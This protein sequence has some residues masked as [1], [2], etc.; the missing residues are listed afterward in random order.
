MPRFSE[1]VQIFQAEEQSRIERASWPFQP[2]ILGDE[3][4][5]RVVRPERP[6][7]NRLLVNV[8]QGQARTP[9]EDDSVGLA[10]L[11]GSR[12]EIG[13]NLYRLADSVVWRLG[14]ANDPPMPVW[15]PYNLM[16][17]GE[18]PAGRKL[19]GP[20]G[21]VFFLVA[22]G[23]DSEY[24]RQIIGRT[25]EFSPLRLT[26]N[27]LVWGDALG[28]IRPTEAWTTANGYTPDPDYDP[29]ALFGNFGNLPADDPVFTG[30]SAGDLLSSDFAAPPFDDVDYFVWDHNSYVQMWRFAPSHSNLALPI[31]VPIGGGRWRILAKPNETIEWPRSGPQVFA[32]GEQRYYTARKIRL[33]EMIVIP[34]QVD[35]AT[36]LW[37]EYVGNVVLT[38]RTPN[39]YRAT[40][41]GNASAGDPFL[42]FQSRLGRLE[43]VGATWSI[44]KARDVYND[45]LDAL[46]AHF[47]TYGVAARES[48]IWGVRDHEGGSLLSHDPTPRGVNNRYHL[49]EWRTSL[50]FPSQPRLESRTPPFDVDQSFRERGERL[51]NAQ[52]VDALGHV[53]FGTILSA[54][55]TNGWGRLLVGFPANHHHL[56]WKRW[57]LVFSGQQAP[58]TGIPDVTD[59]DVIEEL[60][61]QGQFEDG[62]LDGPIYFP[63]GILG[64]IFPTTTL[65]TLTT[66]SRQILDFYLLSASAP[67]AVLDGPTQR[68]LVLSPSLVKQ[69]VVRDRVNL[70]ERFIPA[71][72]DSVSHWARLLNS[73]SREEAIAGFDSGNQIITL[74]I[75]EQVRYKLRYSAAIETTMSLRSATGRV[76][77]IVAIDQDGKRDMTVTAERAYAR[78]V[79]PSPYGAFA[80]PIRS[81][82]FTDPNTRR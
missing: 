68:E 43:S 22:S 48:R 80:V 37:T 57:N 78:R 67:G 10:L 66:T 73:Q 75:V 65:E 76:W 42:Y 2:E 45:L 12:V 26:R 19:R 55:S 18:I 23:E 5:L 58:G 25:L 53:G 33:R 82:Q 15:D 16:G 81:A 54:N 49:R 63:S 64:D 44:D 28:S 13:G 52:F 20:N 79:Q 36:M 46:Q 11:S 1:L 47:D 4:L 59:P 14:A 69:V 60:E 7:A 50:L 17:L 31:G 74:R 34:P 70:V 3:Y 24:I 72:S 6:G 30:H 38:Y 8:Y 61:D 29:D 21:T 77:N 40:E 39:G 9:V 41:L 51:F 35:P 32:T 62:F 71:R 56:E 27:T